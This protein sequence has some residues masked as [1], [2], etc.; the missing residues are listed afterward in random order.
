MA[1]ALPIGLQSKLS[2]LAARQQKLRRLRAVLRVALAALAGATA[3]VLVDALAPLAVPLRLAAVIGWLVAVAWLAWKWCGPAFRRPIDPVALAAVVEAEFPR[4]DER[5]TTSVELATRRPAGDAPILFQLLLQETETRARAIDFTRAAP[6]SAV[7]RSAA[8]LGLLLGVGMA[9]TILWPTHLAGLTRRFVMPWDSRPAVIPFALTVQ[10]GDSVAARGRPFVI[11][12]EVIPLRDRVSLPEHL[13]T[14][15]TAS[16]EPSRRHRMTQIDSAGRYRLEIDRP[17]SDFRYQVEAGEM[18]SAEHRVR[19]VPPVEIVSA[20]GEVI[21]PDYAR[22]EF[23]STRLEPGVLATALQF[24]RIRWTWQFDRRPLAATMIC[25]DAATGV[26]ERISVALA[27][28]GLSG[29][30]DTVV[31]ASGSFRLLAES[32]DGLATE[33]PA[34]IVTVVPDRPPE[35]RRVAGFADLVREI[36]PDEVLPLQW[37]VADDVAVAAVEIELRINDGPIVR[38]PLHSAAI[39]Q[40]EAS[41]STPIRLAGK[42]VIGD[43]VFCRLRALDNRAVP[44]AGLG[45]QITQFPSN[46]RWCEWVVAATSRPLAE[47]EALAERDA[48]DAVIRDLISRLDREIRAMTK[49]SHES[50]DSAEPAPEHAAERERIERAMESIRGD[51]EQLADDAE[52]RGQPG[53]AG[54]AQS[55]A[56]R[57]MQSAAEHLRDAA[58]AAQRPDAL[59]RADRAATQARERLE[60]LQSDNA[61][62]AQQR[63]EA[64]QFHQLAADQEKLADKTEKAE[65]SREQL[66][67]QQS[68]LAESLDKL[69]T[70]SESARDALRGASAELA[71]RL[72]EQAKALAEAQR[73]LDQQIRMAER[74]ENAERLGPNAADQARAAEQVADLYRQLKQQAPGA[75]L[76]SAPEADAA[77]A[78]NALRRGDADI[79]AAHQKKLA[80]HL[81]KLAQHLQKL[82]DLQRDP[83]EAAQYL[84]RWQADARQRTLATGKPDSPDR[85]ELIREQTALLRA[86]E[87]LRVPE[88]SGARREQIDSALKAKQAV[89]ALENGHMNTAA[90]LMQRAKTALDKLVGALPTAEE[91]RKAAREALAKVRQEHDALSRQ[92]TSA[93]QGGRKPSPDAAAEFAR[94]QAEL[95]ERVLKLDA[96]GA[97]QDKDSA[98]A[99]A[100]GALDDLMSGRW[101]DVPASQTDLA[102]ALRRLE[103]AL[104]GK[105]G[106]AQQA[107]E[108]A[109]RQR[110]LADEAERVGGD[111]AR[112]SALQPWQEQIARQLAD[113]D[114]EEAPVRLD[115]AVSAAAE[116]FQALRDRPDDAQTAAAVRRSAERLAELAEQI[117]G[118]ESAAARAARLA[119]QQE[120]LADSAAPTAP[121]TRRRANQVVDEARQIRGGD[122]AGEEKRQAIDAL[123]RAA[124]TPGDMAAGKAAAESL[125]AWARKLGE[126][127]PASPAAAELAQKQRELAQATDTVPPQAGAPR[128]EALDQLAQRQRELR[129]QAARLPSAD[130]PQAVQAAR[131]AMAQ[132]EQALARQDPREARAAQIR[133]AQALDRAAR[134]SAPRA[135]A[136]APQGTPTAQQVQQARDLAAKQRELAQQSAAAARSAQPPPGADGQQSELESKSGELARTLQQDVSPPAANAAQ[137]A[138]AAMRESQQ[139]AGQDAAAA[140]QARLRAAD[141]L[142][143]AAQIAADKA[144]ADSSA[145]GGSPA[146][147]AGQK[148]MQARTQMRSAKESLGQGQPADAGKPMR[149]AAEALRQAADELRQS[150]EQAARRDAAPNA[151][152]AG[153]RSNRPPVSEELAR[154]LQLHPGK[155]WGEL[156]G[157]LRTRILQDVKAQYGDDYAQIIRYYFESL[158]EK[159]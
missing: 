111:A 154:E 133:A 107:R 60:R 146:S 53:I 85:D 95:G 87:Q 91:R 159:K 39:G 21:P 101:H 84:S 57:E 142:D 152:G 130:S 143:R 141:A 104:N 44:E 156:P 30:A 51:L 149:S 38:E 47:R 145:G 122:Q 140:R 94:R 46:D 33:S 12:A 128:T 136:P 10:P 58:D 7:R 138:A 69:A 2:A 157:E 14:V 29:A 15:V 17:T 70:E 64:A 45:P 68:G 88:N 123:A 72:S 49:L 19:V 66:Q 79:A 109:K 132:A 115:A 105:A 153:D 9:A 83:R 3:I 52:R 96:P 137:E 126:P 40:R 74:K 24:S 131:A 129:G 151:P 110:E 61:A 134:E 114:A 37:T 113:L 56:R 118:G 89:T 42:I 27:S 82:I 48:A 23:P 4:L 148:L 90:D 32:T 108:L 102:R 36:A 35:F 93:L 8:W 26:E 98:R 6:V 135:A 127:S 11:D 67:K 22:R 34:V 155:R 59:R 77:E 158:A 65:E 150:A 76:P 20:R 99:A 73:E 78:V 106:P 112:M 18:R 50:A 116:A 147:G 86:I 63:I 55:I 92:I 5:L 80:D 28:D 144:K 124:Q 121:A 120:Q 31:R 41:G 119:Q 62:L 97:D 117:A 54:A 75:P 103:Q 100:G 25:R 71:K 1:T 16:G 13:D 43:R 81:E 139:Q 125:R